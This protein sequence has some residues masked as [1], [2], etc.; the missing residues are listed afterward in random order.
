MS[1]SIDSFRNKKVLVVGDIILDEFV[2]TTLHGVSQ[3]Y[4][5]NPILK[6][7][8]RSYYLGGAANVALNIKKLG[9]SVFLLGTVGVDNFRNTLYELFVKNDISDEFIVTNPKQHTTLKT[10][11]LQ[12]NVPIYRIDEETEVAYDKSIDDYLLFNFKQILET[13]QPDIIILQDYNKGVLNKYLIPSFLQLAKENNIPVCVDPKFLNWTLYCDVDI[14]KPNRVEL[15]QMNN[16]QNDIENT[17]DIVQYAEAVQSK[18]AC[19]NLFITLGSQGT[20]FKNQTES[21]FSTPEKHIV[22]PDVCGAG[23]TVIAVI[24]LAFASQLSWKEIAHLA[25][26]AA[27]IVCHKKHVQPVLW[28]ELKQLHD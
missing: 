26:Q 21:F 27:N 9:A 16:A 3:E 2:E 17:E 1:N 13:Q 28:E 15:M 5:N 14:F 7:K 23:D 18:I 12:N 22:H 6:V 8:S 11:I 24:A 10:R 4:I 25:N 19:K 20:Y